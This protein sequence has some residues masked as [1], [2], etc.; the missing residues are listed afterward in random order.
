M[1]ATTLASSRWQ[2]LSLAFPLFSSLG[3]AHPQGRYFPQFFLL[4]L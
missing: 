1:Q 4:I 3:I 2:E